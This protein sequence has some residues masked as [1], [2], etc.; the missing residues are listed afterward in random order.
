MTT[1]FDSFLRLLT[2]DNITLLLALIGTAGTVYTFVTQRLNL[3]VTV[4]SLR[5]NPFLLELQFENLSSIPV[6]ITHIKLKVGKEE[7]LLPRAASVA[8]PKQKMPAHCQGPARE[9]VL[10]LDFP[11]RLESFGALRGYIGFPPEVQT[12]CSESEQNASIPAT[13]IV[14]TTR[15]KKMQSLPNIRPDKRR[16]SK[17]SP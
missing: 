10:T 13:L 6:S 14:A 3:K 12:L 8:F 2:R 11:V 4:L 9:A 5:D 16:D 7:F 15:G 17:V 1:I